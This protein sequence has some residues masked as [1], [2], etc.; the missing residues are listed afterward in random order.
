M[1]FIQL[2]ILVA[3]IYIGVTIYYWLGQLYEK[4]GK[5]LVMLEHFHE[6]HMHEKKS[7]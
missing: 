4:L 5:V 6:K 3:I 7:N 2:A 1:I